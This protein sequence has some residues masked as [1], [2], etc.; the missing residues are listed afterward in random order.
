VDQEQVNQQLLKQLSRQLQDYIQMKQL[1]KKLLY[2][3]L[4]E[5]LQKD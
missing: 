3:H 5:E 2:L 1:K 4:L